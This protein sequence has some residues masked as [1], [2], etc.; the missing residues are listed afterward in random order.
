MQAN[1]HNIQFGKP[2]FIQVQPACAHCRSDGK[3]H[4]CNASRGED[5]SDLA[6]FFL[7]WRSSRKKA[8]SMEEQVSSRTPLVIST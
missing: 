7:R 1:R 4:S 8:E 3:N 2:K 5:H 6:G